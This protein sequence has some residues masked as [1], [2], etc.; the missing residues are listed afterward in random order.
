MLD[1]WATRLLRRRRLGRPHHLAEA[2]PHARA[3]LQS[4]AKP[5]SIMVVLAAALLRVAGR[6]LARLARA[7]ERVSQQRDLQLASISASISTASARVSA[8]PSSH[9]R[10]RTENIPSAGRS[11][12]SAGRQVRLQHTTSTRCHAAILPL[13]DCPLVNRPMCVSV[14]RMRPLCYHCGCASERPPCHHSLVSGLGRWGRPGLPSEGQVILP[15]KR[16]RREPKHDAIWVDQCLSIPVDQGT[17]SVVLYLF[18]RLSH[19]GTLFR[20]KRRPLLSQQRAS[21]AWKLGCLGA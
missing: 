6:C 8:A 10:G 17:K 1:K 15:R 7:R 2:G 19:R 3:G 11:A 5:T 21:S 18:I 16:L 9:R 13:I 14:S 12:G 4:V 20:I